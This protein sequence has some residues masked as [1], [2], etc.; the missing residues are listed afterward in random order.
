MQ[1]PTITR[2]CKFCGD[3]V[4]G[5]VDK[6]FCDDYCRNNF[7]NRRYQMAE[8]GEE[9]RRTNRILLRNRQIIDELFPET[10][11]ETVV[12]A[13]YLT[14]K[15]FN[16]R[17][18]TQVRTVSTGELHYQCYDV[19]IQPAADGNNWILRR[20]KSNVVHIPI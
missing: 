4:R 13:D 8:Y 7:N 1:P 17:Y 9:V 14:E 6:K 5:R 2:T 18:F 19:V 12:S 16:F 20:K 3:P 11:Q 10:I 15:G